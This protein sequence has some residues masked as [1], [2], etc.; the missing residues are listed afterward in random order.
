MQS[1]V[2]TIAEQKVTN[3]ALQY[4]TRE[5]FVKFDVSDLPP[6]PVY[7]PHVVGLNKFGGSTVDVLLSSIKKL[8]CSEAKAL[9]EGPDHPL[10]LDLH[11]ADDFA[12]KHIFGAINIPIGADDSKFATWVRPA[13]D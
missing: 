5:E 12:S 4:T 6:A 11:D 8:N 2:S 3:I 7:F 1:L 13:S 9:L 10:V